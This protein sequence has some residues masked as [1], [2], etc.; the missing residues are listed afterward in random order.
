MSKK[1][2]ADYGLWWRTTMNEKPNFPS[3][4]GENYT[5]YMKKILWITPYGPYDT[6]GHA[7][8]KTNNFYVKYLSSINK[9]DIV[10]VGINFESE[11]EKSDLEKYRI[12]NNI[13]YMKDDFF[14]TMLRYAVNAIS[15]CNP[16]DLCC[17][18]GGFY[19]RLALHKSVRMYVKNG[20]YPD[21]IIME[22]TQTLFLLPLLKKKYPQSKYLIIE[23]DVS[24]LGYKRKYQAAAHVVSKLFWKYRYHQ[25]LLMEIKLL[26]KCDSICVVNKKDRILL[27]NYGFSFP[28]LNQVVFY[29]DDY[30]T[31]ERRI[32]N[33]DIIYFGAMGR[34]EN[35]LSA[36]WF[37]DHVMPLLKNK[38]V[39]FS[40]IG[41]GVRKKLRELNYPNVKVLGFVPDVSQYFAQSL[42]LVA[43]LVL[44][45]GIKVKIIEAFSA[46]IPVLTNDIGIE[47]IPAIAGE[48]YLHCVTA[49]DYQKAIEGLL[50]GTIDGS[51]IG[52]NAQQL[53][54]QFFNK[55]QIK[56]FV[57]LLENI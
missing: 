32:C 31:V 38:D 14:H 33:K 24:F 37:I 55:D 13:V 41:G 29:Y 19:Q 10:V 6:I 35:H 1:I 40:I 17:G 28:Q 45:A 49:E 30:S 2:E 25:L 34:K 8:G 7:G 22:W 16:F 48:H 9:F 5:K 20:Q 4:V 46:G 43:P 21:I 15:A 18:L 42:C 27:E 56:D 51:T 3:Y 47:G 11:R 54:K 53:V 50:D 44:G 52:I 39:C 23:E 12:K 36:L 26:K 57:S